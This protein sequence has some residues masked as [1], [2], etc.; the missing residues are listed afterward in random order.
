MILEKIIEEEWEEKLELP[1]TER[2][3]MGFR[4]TGGNPPKPT[5]INFISAKAFGRMYKRSK[6]L[7]DQAGLIRSREENKEVTIVA[8]TIS[9]EL[10]IAQKKNKQQAKKLVPRE[11]HDYLTLFEEK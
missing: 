8:T 11:Y 4:S 3:D 7:R 10:A 2:A 5:E 9:T 1:T 6:K